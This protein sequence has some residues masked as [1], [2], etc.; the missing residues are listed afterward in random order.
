M[1]TSICSTLRATLVAASLVVSLSANCL[2]REQNQPDIRYND[3]I[4]V[5]PTGN[6]HDLAAGAV[7]RDAFLSAQ[8]AAPWCYT[9]YGRYPMVV[10]LPAGASCRVNVPFW[11][12]V[13]TGVTGF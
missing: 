9:S 12:Y 6:A 5:S 2:A 13:L 1:K 7:H 11:P 3:M 10:P 8:A 4:S